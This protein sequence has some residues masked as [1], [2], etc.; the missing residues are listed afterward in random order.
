VALSARRIWAS[1]ASAVLEKEPKLSDRF[2]ELVL[3]A[4]RKALSKRFR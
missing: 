4:E 3:E 1:D 2:Y